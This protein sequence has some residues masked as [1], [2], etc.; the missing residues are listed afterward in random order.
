M[1]LKRSIYRDVLSQAQVVSVG[2]KSSRLTRSLI[3]VKVCS[4]CIKAASSELDVIDFPIVLIDD[5]SRATEPASLVPLMKGVSYTY[6]FERTNRKYILKSQH[7]ALVGDHKQL[8]PSVTTRAARKGGLDVSLFERLVAEG[9]NAQFNY[10]SHLTSLLNI[11]V[12]R[13]SH[14][15]A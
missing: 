15:C 8:R 3:S 10:C 2:F 11:S 6:I 9:G 14:S 13:Y 5:A 1:K 12:Y 4:T 7:V